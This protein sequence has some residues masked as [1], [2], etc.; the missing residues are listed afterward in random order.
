[1]SYWEL[2]TCDSRPCVGVV[3]LAEPGDLAHDWQVVDSGAVLLEL[4]GRPVLEVY[5]VL[6][7]PGRGSV[8]VAARFGDSG[9]HAEAL[10]MLQ[11]QDR[12]PLILADPKGRAY[13]VVEADLRRVK[14]ALTAL[15]SFS[16]KFHLER[17][18]LASS[19]T[20]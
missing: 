17:R 1:M 16:K 10:A 9:E 8:R 5:F 15:I 6:Y 20:A 14:A 3:A 13:K 7:S 11:L 18:I 12:I 19:Q 4:H 2:L